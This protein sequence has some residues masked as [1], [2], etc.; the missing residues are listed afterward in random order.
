MKEYGDRFTTDFDENKKIIDQVVDVTSKKIRN[1]L[2][3][4]MTFLK[5]NEEKI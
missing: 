1:K 4:Y 2:A 3:G 5:K